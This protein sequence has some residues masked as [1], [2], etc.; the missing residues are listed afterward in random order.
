MKNLSM[1]KITLMT[2]SIILLSFSLSFIIIS[3]FLKQNEQIDKFYENIKLTIEV[4]NDVIVNDFEH[5]II[6]YYS[7]EVKPPFVLKTQIIP[8]ENSEFVKNIFDLNVYVYGIKNNCIYL[9]IRNKDDFKNLKFKLD[10]FFDTHFSKLNLDFKFYITDLSGKFIYGNESYYEKYKNIHFIKDTFKIKNFYMSYFDFF[11]FGNK[12]LLKIYTFFKPGIFDFPLNY[13]K[14]FFYS[15]IISIIIVFIYHFFLF[16]FIMSRFN[17]NKDI[18]KNLNLNSVIKK[19]DYFKT[20][21]TSIPEF[22]ELFNSFFYII[23]SLKIPLQTTISENKILKNKLDRIEKENF[24]IITFL[25]SFK[26]FIY[27]EYDR[28]NFE[29]SINK[30]IAELPFESELLRQNLNNLATKLNIKVLE[31]NNIKNNYYSQLENLFN[32][33]GI[34]SESK[35]YNYIHNYLL[36]DISL[37]LGKQIELDELKLKGLYYGA[38]IHDLG[39]IFI[40]ENI[41]LKKG[42]LNE[43]E[44]K[45][46]RKHTKLGLILLNNINIFPFSNAGKIIISHH[47]N[48]DGSGYPYGLSKDEIPI[49]GR[50]V[51]IVDTLI[52]LITKK[53]YRNAYSFEEAVEIIKS[54]SGKR[55]D[56]DLIDIFIKNKIT[57]KKIINKNIE[58]NN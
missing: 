58:S 24:A 38:K 17:I 5:T 51:A 54:D 46:V 41:L 52:A 53:V 47:E 11:Y 33:V 22:D 13:F 39:K 23:N 28:R 4:I 43:N 14:S 7:S 37:F 31:I 21:E 30:L 6:N 50:I 18:I 35:E 19:K 57:I 9:K 48:W 10:T 26:K 3:S 49:E 55:F 16:K 44:W 56:P 34:M 45:I 42:P 32:I 15:F 1:H 20:I 40:P 36:G 29:L 12:P 27:E 25:S 2:M 8:F